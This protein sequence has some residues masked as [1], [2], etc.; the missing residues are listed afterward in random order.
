[1]PNPTHVRLAATATR[2][3]ALHGRPMQLLESTGGSDPFNP[4]E[5]ETTQDFIGVATRF[6]INEIDGSTIQSSDRKYLLDAVIEPTT[7]HR[8]RDGESDYSIVNV[9]QVAPGET[10]IIYKV[11][12]RL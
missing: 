5:T 4:V 8:L 1:M 11:Q 6:S 7:A 2:L 10:S 12:A 9:D 3:I